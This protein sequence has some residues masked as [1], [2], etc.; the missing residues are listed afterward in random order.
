[1][2]RS[3]SLWLDNAKAIL[4][5]LVVWGHLIEQV[6]LL[7]GT[8]KAVFSAIYVFHM[9]AFVVICGMVSRAD[10]GRASLAEMARRLVLPLVVFQIL[11]W[12]V[13][14]LLAPHKVGGILTP[15]WILWFLAS[16]MAWRLMLPLF[17]QLRYPVVVAVGI[18]LAAGY[19]GLIDQTL[20][21]SRTLFFFPAFLFGHLH[22]RVVVEQLRTRKRLCALAF[23]MICLGAAWIFAHGA[24]V[25]PLFG[26]Q[27][28]AA[29]SDHPGAQ[30]LIR[31]LAI[32]FGLTASV[33]FLA[34]VPDKA[35]L[36]SR[37]GRQTFSVYLW[38]GF[39]VVLFWTFIRHNGF[40]SETGFLALS[41]V[42]A[43]VVTFALACIAEAVSRRRH[44][45]PI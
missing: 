23:A 38:H 3:R 30:A 35:T 39:I 32:A 14:G 43:I 12:P 17:V 25:K 29:M 1:M 26:S 18:T 40:G 22:G 24:S 7:G 20:S 44:P 16:L 4:I 5:V 11:Y 42:F 21:L 15:H 6:A 37:V 33:F 9:P 10:T 34:L 8:T 41:A 13:L 28:Y 36:L 31:L 19:I 2:I 45:L 27:P